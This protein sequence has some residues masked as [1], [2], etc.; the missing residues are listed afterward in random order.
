MFQVEESNTTEWSLRPRERTKGFEDPD[1]LHTKKFKCYCLIGSLPAGWKKQ[2][3]V[4]AYAYWGQTLY[5]Q[6]TVDRMKSSLAV[7][8][9]H[10]N[11]TA[12]NLLVVVTS[13]N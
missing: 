9:Y 1:L 11:Q 4:K 13:D 7:V 8:F 3:S 10:V 12:G 6:S 5:V 2:F